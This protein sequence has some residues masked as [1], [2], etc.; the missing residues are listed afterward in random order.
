M[1]YIYAHLRWKKN[2]DN[3]FL[4]KI[5]LDPKQFIGI[6]KNTIHC[7]AP[8]LSSKD[9]SEGEIQELQELL[10]DKGTLCGCRLFFDVVPKGCKKSQDS[11][12][13]VW[14]IE[15]GNKYSLRPKGY[16]KTKPAITKTNICEANDY[17]SSSE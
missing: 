2:N 5:F 12:D 6:R 13:Q 17:E 15:K 10:A 11:K 7:G 8:G 9:L 1:C 14:F 3:L 16:Q 4:K